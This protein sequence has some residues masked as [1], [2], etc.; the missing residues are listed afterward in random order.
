MMQSS[1]R[2]VLPSF[3][4]AFA[5]LSAVAC[6]SKAGSND[7]SASQ[8][9]GS[10][11]PAEDVQGT[12]QTCHDGDTCRIKVGS[13]IVTVR[14]AGIDAPEVMGGPDNQGQPYGADARDYLRSRI[15]GKVVTLRKLGTDPY[16]RT[17]GEIFLDGKQIG[18]ELVQKG[19]AEHYKWATVKINKAAYV[20][21]ESQ[22]KSQK[23][24]IWSL[25]NYESPGDFRAANPE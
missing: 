2:K 16:E 5:A 10:D 22:A 15:K 24:G 3:T 21:A 4:L 14:M 11:A 6:G 25:E 20:S 19:L 12:V 1:I 9:T 8:S 13:E 18:L 23:L 17:L 7:A